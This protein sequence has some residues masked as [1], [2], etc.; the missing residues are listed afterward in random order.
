MITPN[1]KRDYTL[2][3]IDNNKLYEGKKKVKEMESIIYTLNGIV[4]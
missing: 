1:K 3:P 2:V 4:P